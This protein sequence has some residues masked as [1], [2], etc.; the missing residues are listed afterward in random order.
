MRQRASS[1]A[2]T[3]QHS[4]VFP[5]FE[6]YGVSI[7]V[8]EV[9]GAIDPASEAHELITGAFGGMSKGERNRIKVRVRTAMS[10]QSQ[11]EGRYL[12]GRPPYGYR[13]IAA[14]AHPNPGKAAE[15]KRLHQLAP[16]PDTAPVVQR[17]FD[18]CCSG[19][20]I[21]AIAEGLTRDGV[22][23]PA[24]TTP[25]ATRTAPAPPGPKAPCAPSCSTRATPATKSGTNNARK[26]SSSTSTTSHSATTAA[27]PHTPSTTE[28]APKPSANGSPTPKQKKPKHTR[29][30]ANTT[31]PRLNPNPR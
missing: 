23:S 6:H 2:S 24:L 10:S 29:S 16:D 17:I 13:L 26:K 12:G 11:L 5:L 3:R 4:L 22:P 31:N 28:P 1:A 30:C 21:Y 15:G 27:K 19:H 14:G 8:P 18:E 20:G 25:P 7:W 9:G